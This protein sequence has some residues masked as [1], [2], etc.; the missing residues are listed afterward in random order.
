M[1]RW[2]NGSFYQATGSNIKAHCFMGHRTRVWLPT[3]LWFVSC[4]TL[5]PIVF[6]SSRYVGTVGDSVAL[7]CC[8][9]SQPVAAYFPSKCVKWWETAVFLW[10]PTLC[11]LQSL[12]RLEVLEPLSLCRF[13]NWSVASKASGKYRSEDQKIMWFYV[14]HFL[15]KLWEQAFSNLFFIKLSLK[16]KMSSSSNRIVWYTA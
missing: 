11:Y 3:F 12:E 2:S 10:E 14:L 15:C 13:Q 4:S 5:W 7:T 1:S 6:S 8:L 16:Q 9:A